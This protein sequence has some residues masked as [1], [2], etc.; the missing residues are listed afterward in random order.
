MMVQLQA[1]FKHDDLLVYCLLQERTDPIYAMAMC[2]DWTV[3]INVVRPRPS[4]VRVGR[5]SVGQGYRSERAREK[6]YQG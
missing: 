3:D 5:L 4:R 1:L 2:K 6:A